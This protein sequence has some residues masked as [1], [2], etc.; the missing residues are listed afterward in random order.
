VGDA[1]WWCVR[2]GCGEVGGSSPVS[3]LRQMTVVLRPV[4]V[5]VQIEEAKGVPFLMLSASVVLD[6]GIIGCSYNKGA[7][8]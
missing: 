8:G 3:S 7:V 4:G 2:A 5:L 1:A 6:S